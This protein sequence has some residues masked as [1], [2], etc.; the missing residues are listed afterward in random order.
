MSQTIPVVRTAPDHELGRLLDRAAGALSHSHPELGAELTARAQ[1]EHEPPDP[2]DAFAG[3]AQ[4]DWFRSF[5][6]LVLRGFFTPEL[7]EELRAEVVRTMLAVHGDRYHERPPMSGMAGHHTCLLG[8]WAPRTVELVD[9]RMLVGLAERLV[10]G[11]VLPSPCD[12]QGIRYF[13]H[14]GWHNDT[15][16]GIRGVKFVAYLE[17]LVG[18]TGALRVLTGS[19]RLPHAG[20]GHLD[21]LDLTVPEVPG[22]V[23]ATEPGDVIAFDPLLYHATWGGKDRHQWSTMYLR[24]AVAPSWRAGLLDWYADGAQY[25]DE[26]PEGFRPF[27]RSWVAEGS[28]DIPDPG[29]AQR[30]MWMYRLNRMGVLTTYG[31]A[32]AYR[33]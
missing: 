22:I 18:D 19:H 20:L 4:V 3:D 25:L 6:Y 7:V 30:H 21:S 29:L 26:L 10:G 5:G 13:D 15:G 14:A 17:P 2:F 9:G 1:R 11:G 31:V 33:P 12:T 8:P 16:I 28:G 27:D 23:L 24:D 32:D